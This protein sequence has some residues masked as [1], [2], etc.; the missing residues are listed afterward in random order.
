MPRGFD[1]SRLLVNTLNSCVVT[2]EISGEN[3]SGKM[4]LTL[5]MLCPPLTK[6]IRINKPL[7]AQSSM[8]Q[9][10]GLCSSNGDLSTNHEL[11]SD[12]HTRKTTI[13]SLQKLA[14]SLQKDLAVDTCSLRRNHSA[15]KSNALQQSARGVKRLQSPTSFGDVLEP[16]CTPKTRSAKAITKKARPKS[17]LEREI[18]AHNHSPERKN[19]PAKTF[20][21]D[22]DTHAVRL[23]RSV[24]KNLRKLAKNEDI[25][26]RSSQNLLSLML[27][28][29]DTE[30]DRKTYY[31]EGSAELINFGQVKAPAYNKKTDFLDDEEIGEKQQHIARAI[32]KSAYSNPFS[33]PQSYAA[34]C[35]PRLVSHS[36]QDVLGQEAWRDWRKQK[37]T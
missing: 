18:S 22:D 35:P 13:E 25:T 5:T 31:P 10:N 32:E 28:Q 24:E 21:F 15:V 23:T 6:S 4:I 19:V 20:D 37:G 30:R 1:V 27:A 2:L 9:D 17:R 29:F 11:S 12:L 26:P 36:V 7:E 14:G 34:D 33:N 3:S 16:R 8:S